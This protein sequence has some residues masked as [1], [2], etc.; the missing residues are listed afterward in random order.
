MILKKLANKDTF[1]NKR[2]PYFCALNLINF[3]LE[4]M[5]INIGKEFTERKIKK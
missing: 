3:K 1:L 5:T 2:C 4:R